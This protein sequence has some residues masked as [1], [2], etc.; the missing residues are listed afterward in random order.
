MVTVYYTIINPA[1]NGVMVVMINEKMIEL[2]QFPPLVFLKNQIKVISLYLKQ[3]VAFRLLLP[4]HYTGPVHNNQCC[5]I[6]LL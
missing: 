1:R 5:T 4:I 3:T 2:M 6:C